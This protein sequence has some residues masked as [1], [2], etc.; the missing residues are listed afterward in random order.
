MENLTLVTLREKKDS[1]LQSLS[2]LN[3]NLFN[4][5]L[6]ASSKLR[7]LLSDNIPNL[8]EVIIETTSVKIS[9]TR[10]TG[11]TNEIT[12]NNS[13]S[14]YG[15]Y[16]FN[17]TLNWVG[18]T[19]TKNSQNTSL[20]YLNGVVY[21]SNEISKENSEFITLLI[22]TMQDINGMNI[23]I[24]LVSR[25][26]TIV[27]REIDS[28]ELQIKKDLFYS[29]VKQGNYYYTIRTAYGKN[30]YFITKIEKINP[31]TITLTASYPVSDYLTVFD[32]MDNNAI[33]IKKVK[34]EELYSKLNRAT[35][36]N[37]KDFKDIV[38]NDKFKMAIDVIKNAKGFM[39]LND[40]KELCKELKSRSYTTENVPDN[41]TLSYISKWRHETL[42]MNKVS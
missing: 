39:F 26:L 29:K 18:G 9:I 13:N 15:N 23:E 19:I 4:Y 11:Y 22:N 37:K 30:I 28:T 35:L 36:F 17:P 33:T 32:D 14:N 40:M 5:K 25:S 10:N 24:Q 16:V 41:E 8:L 20:N 6:K 34:K 7:E 12:I 2:D 27:N 3:V 38:M 42:K 1:I 31:K 21:I